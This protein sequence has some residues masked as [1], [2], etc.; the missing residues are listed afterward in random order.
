MNSGGFL[1]ILAALGV[2]LYVVGQ[3]TLT[4]TGAAATSTIPQTQVPITSSGPLPMLCPG[5]PGCPGSSTSSAA[6]SI[7]CSNLAPGTYPAGTMQA[8][9]LSGLGSL[10]RMRGPGGWAA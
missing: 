5:D 3:Q 4:T 6:S 9:G 8:C 10:F 1:L 2:A 7:D